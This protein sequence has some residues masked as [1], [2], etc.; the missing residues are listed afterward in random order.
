MQRP[1]YEKYNTGTLLVYH[2]IHLYRSTNTPEH[3]W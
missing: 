1:I 3:I 2:P